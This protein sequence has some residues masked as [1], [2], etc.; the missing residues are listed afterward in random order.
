MDA[1]AKHV[2]AAYEQSL[3]AQRD[4]AIR[5]ELAVRSERD[6]HDVIPF[7][8]ELAEAEVDNRAA[9]TKLEELELELRRRREDLQ[10]RESRTRERDRARESLAAIGRAVV[11]LAEIE[12]LQKHLVAEEAK[13]DGIVSAI[14]KFE[15]DL[16]EGANEERARENA[17]SAVAREMAEL[18]QAFDTLENALVAIADHIRDEDTS[19]PVCRTQFDHGVLRSLARDA[20]GAADPRLVEADAR[21]RAANAGLEEVRKQQAKRALDHRKVAA[22][23]RAAQDNIAQLQSRV[24]V[25]FTHPLLAGRG[26]EEARLELI[27]SRDALREDITRVESEIALPPDLNALKQAVVAATTASDLQK[28]AQ[29][30]AEERRVG[31]QTRIEQLRARIAQSSVAHPELA[32]DGELLSQLVLTRA[33]EASQL[34]D[35]ADAASERSVESAAIAGTARQ[36]LVAAEAEVAKVSA[37]SESLIATRDELERRWLHR[38]LDEGISER[39][40]DAELE[41]LAERKRLMDGALASIAGL[42][43]ALNRW[44]QADELQGLEEEARRYSGSIDHAAF[45]SQLDETVAAATASAAAAQRAREASDL[46]SATLNKVAAEFGGHALR[47]FDELFR[48]YL[49]ALIHDER[50]HDIEATYKPA[51]RAAGLSFKVQLGGM[52]TEAEYIL[53]EGQLGEVSLATMLAASS[54]FPWSRWRVLLLDDPTQYNDLIHSTALV[55]VLRN[56]VRFAGYQIF[57]STHDNEQASFIRRKLDAIGTAWVDCRYVAH[58]P[59]GIVTEVRTSFSDASAVASG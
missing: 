50:F 30:I 26:T 1:A 25:L 10:T 14:Q 34:K 49:R 32:S 35:A 40:L 19:C 29:A 3:E 42:A 21:W 51:A 31:R 2:R 46:L 6:R 36:A 57:V 5:H 52:N 4:A 8:A 43:A 24:A 33:V 55:D 16:E 58:S 23:L 13:R 44:R 47:P 39:N 17:A 9:Q 53:S 48:R 15:S 28:R 22:D 20:I 7:E 59:E 54:A 18:R 37:L 45:S 56:L 38:G 11:A 41:K 27:R 12:T